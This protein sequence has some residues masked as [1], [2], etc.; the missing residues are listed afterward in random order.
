M[1][2]QGRA[3]LVTSFGLF[4]FMVNYSLTEF[5]STVILYSIDS[6]LTD[7]EFLFIDVILA[8]NFAFFFGKTCAYNGKLSK[9]PPMSSLISF[10]PLFSLVIQMIVI[11]I[12]QVTVFFMVQSQPWFTPYINK[13]DLNYSCYENYSVFCISIF[14]YVTLAIIFS[15]GTP[16]RKPIY[17]NF[18]FVSSLILTATV[19]I[20]ITLGPTEWISNFIQLMMPPTIHWKLTILGL[21]LINFILCF[22]IEY[23]LIEFLM[24]KKIKSCMYKPESSKKLYLKLEHE[25]KS[26]LNWPPISQ[27]FPV[28][29]ITPRA[30]NIK[31]SKGLKQHNE[32][33]YGRI[34]QN[35]E[36]NRVTDA[37]NGFDNLAFISNENLNQKN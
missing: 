5:I 3:A 4:K 23:L 27:E 32:D 10:T 21:A 2:R 16:Y 18:T 20:Y 24:E 34:T 31:L 25:L 6:N 30:V 17:T 15:R 9:K 14:Q 22:I 12:F 33:S 35:E 37:R 29:P 13:D 1:I 11:I 19:C 7:L 8:M 36:I 26:D 28:L